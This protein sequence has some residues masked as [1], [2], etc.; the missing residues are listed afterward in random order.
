MTGF[1]DSIGAPYTEVPPR[2]QRWRRISTRRRTDDVWCGTFVEFLFSPLFGTVFTVLWLLHITLL[3][4]WIILQKRSPAATMAW[5]LSLAAIPYFGFLIYWILGP[6]RIRRTRLRQARARA[7]IAEARAVMLLASDDAETP[8]SGEHL[9]VDHTK[10]HEGL[11]RLA[12]LSAAMPLSHCTSVDLLDDG[13]A[14]YDAIVEA[15]QSAENHVHVEYYIFEPDEVGTR[16]RDAL[17]ERA[18]AGVAVRVVLDAVG[19]AR[20]SRAFLRPLRQ[21]GGQVVFFHPL[22][23]FRVRS[24]VN[25]RTHRK[26]VVVDGRVGFTGGFNITS[27]E[28]PR[29]RKY[30]YRD[31]HV[32]L[33]GLAVRWL[34]IVFLEDFSYATGRYLAPGPECFPEVTE[35]ARH[36]VQIVP[37]GPYGPWEPIRDLFFAAI[38]SAQTRILVTTPYF[39]PDDPMRVALTTAALRGVEVSILVPRKSDSW[40]VTFA[41]RSYFDELLAAGARIFEYDTMLHAKTLVVDE[42]F[43]SAG[44]A[45]MDARS[46]RLNFEVTAAFYGDDLANRLSAHFVRDL[47][48]AREVSVRDRAVLSFGHRLCEAFSRLMSPLL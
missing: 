26:I 21:A 4:G 1:E 22:Q 3:S 30:P 27:D 28:E 16:V 48:H 24:L 19:S 13:S 39:V 10:W 25:L 36:R 29:H 42:D 31:T 45:N 5:I 37:S 20:I 34:Q 23:P 11:A 35:P 12:R 7:A 8:A 38:A 44:T 9:H 46:F 6:R 18:Q 2:M 32:R 33:T 47:T 40:L 14:T 15:I 41:G 17:V 43:S